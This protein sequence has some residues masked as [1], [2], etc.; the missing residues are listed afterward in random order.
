[1][2]YIHLSMLQK[3][4]SQGKGTTQLASWMPCRANHQQV[5]CANVL[6]MIAGHKPSSFLFRAC[7]SWTAHQ[8][9]AFCCR[10]LCAS[11]PPVWPQSLCLSLNIHMRLSSLNFCRLSFAGL[12]INPELTLTL[13]RPVHCS[14]LA[15]KSC[16]LQASNS[17]VQL[18]LLAQARVA[19]ANAMQKV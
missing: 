4:H 9:E 15:G 18:S 19:E 12:S 7:C 2:S 3:V 1:M 10:Q 17:R 6:A 11:K 5:G 16:E 8:H 13:D 14:L